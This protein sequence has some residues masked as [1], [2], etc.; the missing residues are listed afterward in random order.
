MDVGWWELSRDVH[1][2]SSC[3]EMLKSLHIKHCSNSQKKGQ[4]FICMQDKHYEKMQM[5]HLF[6]PS[7]V[8][9]SGNCF[10]THTTYVHALN[11][12][13]TNGHMLLGVY[14]CVH[15]KALCSIVLSPG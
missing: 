5:A 3:M 12:V 1:C 6:L 4:S 9:I 10:M 13:H 7:Q 8:F 11:L 15:S 14:Q 2:L